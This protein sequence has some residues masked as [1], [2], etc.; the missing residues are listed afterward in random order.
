MNFQAI[1]FFSDDKQVGDG[2]EYFEKW[3]L[4]ASEINPFQGYFRKKKFPSDFMIKCIFS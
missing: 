2:S 3:I 1:M 4:I